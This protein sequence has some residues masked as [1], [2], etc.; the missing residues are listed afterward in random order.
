MWPT[1]AVEWKTHA[2]RGYPAGVA[3]LSAWVGM[4]VTARP[5]QADQAPWRDD[6]P[7]R[8]SCGQLWSSSANNPLLIRDATQMADD[9]YQ[10]LGALAATGPARR[11]RRPLPVAS[12]VLGD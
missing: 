5:P 4:P 11:S 12:S 10:L 3:W 7:P 6:S 9:L 1:L 2:L 8:V